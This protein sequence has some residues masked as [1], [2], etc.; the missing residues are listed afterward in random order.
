RPAK[1][2]V[3]AFR[4]AART[5]WGHATWMRA[6]RR[7]WLVVTALVGVAAVGLGVG[8]AVTTGGGTPGGATAFPTSYLIVYRVVT[9]GVPQW[10]ILAA[11][12]PFDGS[13]LT[14]RTVARPQSGDAPAGG[15]ISTATGLFT[16]SS[17]RVE[18]VSG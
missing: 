7:R 18:L 3:R 14:Y 16:V 1:I 12:R 17:G 11:H 13:D 5:R 4:R 2:E 9:N 10:E 15:T 6:R 8:W